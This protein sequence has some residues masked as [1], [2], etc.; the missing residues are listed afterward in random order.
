MNFLFFFLQKVLFPYGADRGDL[1]MLRG[2]DA[3]VSYTLKQPFPF[4]T[5]KYRTLQVKDLLLRVTHR[6][7]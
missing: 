4:F 3:A 1:S 7:C 6:F 2:D 5:K